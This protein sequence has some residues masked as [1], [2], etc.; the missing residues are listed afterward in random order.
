MLRSGSHPGLDSVMIRIHQRYVTLE[1]FTSEYDQDHRV[2]DLIRG[3]C[4]TECPSSCY[5]DTHC[6]P[7]E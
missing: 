7:V 6:I 4:S 1:S 5:Y 2:A 3:I